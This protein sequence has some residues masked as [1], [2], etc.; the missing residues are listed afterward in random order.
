MIELLLKIWPM[1]LALG[2]V[3]FAVLK[4]P[5]PM[6]GARKAAILSLIHASAITSATLHLAGA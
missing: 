6:S 3:T 5:W 1:L 4:S 2:V